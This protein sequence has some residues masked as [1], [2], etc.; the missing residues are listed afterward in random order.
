[1]G[2]FTE[3]L[4]ISSFDICTIFF[5]ILKNAFEA[6]DKTDEKKVKLFIGVKNSS[7]II[8]LKNSA[9][10][11]PLMRNNIYISDKSESGHGYG[12]RNVKNCMEKLNG[13]FELEYSEED[14]AVT[15]NLLIFKAVPCNE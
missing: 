8:K 14:K 10:S 9:L 7:L 5:N 4:F 2:Y 15:V 12:L 11:A 3:K 13:S 1:M 6:A